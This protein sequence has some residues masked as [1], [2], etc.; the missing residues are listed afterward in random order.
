MPGQGNRYRTLTPALTVRDGNKMIEFY[1]RAFGAELSGDVAR[2]PDGRV[3]HAEMK[4]GD[5]IFMLGEEFPDWGVVAPVSLGDKNSSSLHIYADDADATFA[6]AVAAGAKVVT[7]MSDAFWGDRYG[8]VT[9]PSGHRW[10][11]ATH[12]R[13]VPDE[14]MKE[15]VQKMTPA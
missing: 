14:E 9:D 2:M 7:P 13:D 5:S 11:I 10:G 15:A 6:K 12:V 3:M 4:I 8:V 1:R